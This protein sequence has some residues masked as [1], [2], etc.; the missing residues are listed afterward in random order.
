MADPSSPS[1]GMRPS[2]EPRTAADTLRAFTDAWPWPCP[3][4]HPFHLPVHALRP[5]LLG[6][7]NPSCLMAA[8]DPWPRITCA[9]LEV[10]DEAMGEHG[11]IVGTPE[12][13]ATWGYHWTTGGM[14]GCRRYPPPRLTSARLSSSGF[15]H[16]RDVLSYGLAARG[17]SRG[18]L[19]ASGRRHRSLV[20]GSPPDGSR[21]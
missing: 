15:P 14:Q 13:V 12:G 1:Q 8:S 4:V 16:R 6:L 20:G 21:Q 2:L 3:R 9:L 5:P 10:H 17:C 7:L 19:P 18:P 11:A